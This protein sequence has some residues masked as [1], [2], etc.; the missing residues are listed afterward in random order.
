MDFMDYQ[1]PGNTMPS[2]SAQPAEPAD[3]LDALRNLSQPTYTYVPGYYGYAY[4]YYNQS[5]S[6]W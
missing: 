4:P 5:S 3:P 1:Y 2:Q 6:V